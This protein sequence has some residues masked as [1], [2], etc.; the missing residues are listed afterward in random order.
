VSRRLF[1]VGVA[2]IALLAACNDDEGSGNTPAGTREHQGLMWQNPPPEQS[3]FQS[4]AAQ[5]CAE[6]SLGGFDDWRL[7]TID[8][9]RRLIA[10][11]DGR[12]LGGACR[13]S[14]PHCLGKNCYDKNTCGHCPQGKGP[15]D[16]CYWGAGW[17]GSCTGIW[18]YWSLSTYNGFSDQFWVVRFQGGGPFDDGVVGFNEEL[19]RG[20][21]RCVRGDE[22][23]APTPDPAQPKFDDLDRFCIASIKA[24]DEVTLP[25]CMKIVADANKVTAPGDVKCAEAAN[26]C[27]DTRACLDAMADKGG[28]ATQ[29]SP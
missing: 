14:D 11:C 25:T 16:G 4:A 17:S 19:G 7:P 12:E 5:Y 27:D 8:E 29:P 2:L 24:S 9:L 1:A 13:V 3:F 10:G 15:S 22:P 18:F 26:S 6:L 21:V 23:E 28:P 20:N